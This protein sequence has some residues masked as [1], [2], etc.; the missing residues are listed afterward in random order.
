MAVLISDYEPSLRNF[1]RHTKR[2]SDMEENIRK[3]SSAIIFLFLVSC[4]CVSPSLFGFEKTSSQFAEEVRASQSFYDN[5]VRDDPSNATA[6]CIRG[7]YYNNAF[8][9]Y[10]KAL[11]SYNRSLELDPH[12]GYAWFSKGVTLHNMG[13]DNESRECFENA[14]RYDPSIG[15]SIDQIEQ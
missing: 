10:E 12:Y 8:N 15:P 14:V 7:N 9:Q 5:P 2:I 13:Y 3:F 6:W 4:G 1:N 11:A